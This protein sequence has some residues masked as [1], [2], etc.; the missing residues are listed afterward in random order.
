MSSE[1]LDALQYSTILRNI[2]GACP[3]YITRKGKDPATYARITALSFLLPL[4]V[5]FTNLA[6]F[7]TAIIIMEIAQ[8]K[9]GIPIYDDNLFGAGAS[10]KTSITAIVLGMSV[11]T[12]LIT[13]TFIVFVTILKRNS[14]LKVFQE[15]IEIFDILDKNYGAK[16]DAFMLKVSSNGILIVALIYHTFS[17]Y[18]FATF[19]DSGPRNYIFSAIVYFVEVLGSTLATFDLICVL[20]LKCILFDLMRKKISSDKYDSEL[21]LTFFKTL[22]LVEGI[23][24]CQGSRECVNIGNQLFVIISQLFVITYQI[25]SHG[26]MNV[27]VLFGTV[28]LLPRIFNLGLIAIYGSKM[29]DSVS[30]YLVSIDF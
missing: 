24:L 30:F 3:Y 13:Y 4:L 6:L 5:Y 19:V 25:E 27:P 22:D 20:N 29:S 12:N 16:C 26:T 8:K 14:W 17:Y 21:F 10:T 9:H 11:A 7:F 28:G 23:S 2:F 18:V 15:T 1:V